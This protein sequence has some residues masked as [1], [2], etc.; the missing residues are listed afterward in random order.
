MFAFRMF[1]EDDIDGVADQ[2]GL[3]VAPENA[4]IEQAVTEISFSA[5]VQA[6]GVAGGIAHKN[7]PPVIED[8]LAVHHHPD[9]RKFVAPESPPDGPKI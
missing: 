8:F 9:R 3:I 5:D 7:H 1:F 6:D 4:D 2:M